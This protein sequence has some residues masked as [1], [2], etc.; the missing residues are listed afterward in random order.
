MR[1][2]FLSSFLVLVSC[3]GGGGSDASVTAG[4]S[5]SQ[6]QAQELIKS[7]IQSLQSGQYKIDDKDLALLKKEGLLSQEELNSLSVVK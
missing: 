7:E 4:M 5:T 6:K 3:S 2:L 1:I